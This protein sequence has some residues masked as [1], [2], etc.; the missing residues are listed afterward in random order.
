MTNGLSGSD[1]SLVAA[2]AKS[3]AS[4]GRG[5]MLP[6]ENADDST[7]GLAQ[8]REFTQNQGAFFQSDGSKSSHI[9]L[10]SYWRAAN[11]HSQQRDK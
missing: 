1:E 11:E 5:S 7:H 10:R 9:N 4:L 8:L 3:K 6:N 2:R